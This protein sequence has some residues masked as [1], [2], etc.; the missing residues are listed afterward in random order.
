MF[1]FF[2]FSSF[3]EKLIKIYRVSR[4]NRVGR[5]TPIKPFFFRPRV[6][7]LLV[8]N[9]YSILLVITEFQINVELLFYTTRYTS[10]ITLTMFCRVPF[11]CN[12]WDYSLKKS[13]KQL[14][15]WLELYWHC[16]WLSLVSWK[17]FYSYLEYGVIESSSVLDFTVY[18]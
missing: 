10:G 17:L 11:Y 14:R 12:S 16:F 4:V 7:M 6:K 1:F 5:V 2:F 18:Y 13:W 8:Q 3:F 9:L 15:I